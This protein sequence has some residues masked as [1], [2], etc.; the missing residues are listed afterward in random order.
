MV[1]AIFTD[2]MSNAIKVRE[3]NEDYHRGTALF[4]FPCSKSKQMRHYVIPTLAESKPNVCLIPVGS[5]ELPT[6]KGEPSAIVY[7]SC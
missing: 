4:R 5:N 2:S 7:C 6:K 3:F 1:T